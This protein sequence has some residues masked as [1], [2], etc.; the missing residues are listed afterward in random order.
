MNHAAQGSAAAALDV[1]NGT[2][3]GAG[4]GETAEEA[5]KGVAYALSHKLAVAVVLSLGDV[6]GYHR[7]EQRVD[8]AEAGK[9]Q[10]WNDGSGEDRAPIDGC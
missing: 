9:G 6:V 10:A 2:H 8:G 4:A 1:D 7:G 3:G 5:G